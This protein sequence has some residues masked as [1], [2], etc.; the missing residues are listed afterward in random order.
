MNCLNTSVPT[1]TLKHY[2]GCLLLVVKCQRPCVSFLK[3]RLVR[4]ELWAHSESS[5]PLSQCVFPFALPKFLG[6]Q[7][8]GL[9]V[10]LGL[11]PPSLQMYGCLALR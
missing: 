2:F 10:S 8:L 9:S 7:H 6:S 3:L 1:G 4:N 5:W 11:S